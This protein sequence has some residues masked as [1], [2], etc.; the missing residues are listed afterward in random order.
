M[1]KAERLVGGEAQMDE[2]LKGLFQQGGTEMP[3]YL[4]WQDF[5]DACGLTEEQLNL[6]GGWQS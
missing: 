4:T 2:I 6:E 5:L 3:P 1:L